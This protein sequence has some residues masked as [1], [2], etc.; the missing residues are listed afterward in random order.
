MIAAAFSAAGG[1]SGVTPRVWVKPD[2]G[3]LCP[4][5]EEFRWSLHPGLLRLTVEG[6]G[7]VRARWQKGGAEYANLYLRPRQPPGQAYDVVYTG[8]Q[9]NYRVDGLQPG[10][11][12]EFALALVEKQTARRDET[13]EDGVAKTHL[14]PTGGAVARLSCGYV[15]RTANRVG[16]QPT[17]SARV[18]VTNNAREWVGQ[19]RVEL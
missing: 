6:E 13:Y 14:T 9:A 17:A 15:A 10:A 16:R 2:A 4:M 3:H 19:E 11:E 8:P 18:E 12:Y 7:S 1:G 5:I